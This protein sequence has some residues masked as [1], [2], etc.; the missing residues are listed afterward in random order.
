MR[1]T[2]LMTT[3]TAMALTAAPALADTDHVRVPEIGST[4]SLAAIV[5]V[6]A[7]AMILWERRRSAH[8]L[9]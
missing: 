6:V 3:L 1:M 5:A 8:T 9:K 2:T 7:L 4:G